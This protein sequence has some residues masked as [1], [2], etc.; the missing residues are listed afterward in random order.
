MVRT[1]GKQKSTRLVLVCVALLGFG[2]IADYLWASS[3]HF[4]SSTSFSNW[5]PTHNPQTNLIIPNKQPHY[6]DTNIDTKSQQKVQSF[7]SPMSSLLR[8]GDSLLF[9]MWDLVSFL[10][11]L[12]TK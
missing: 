4:A 8:S 12:K 9:M 2:L 6:T 11:T 3:P 10:F 5:V 1:S 7:F